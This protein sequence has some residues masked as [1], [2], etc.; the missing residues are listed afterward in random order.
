MSKYLIS[1]GSRCCRPVVV[2]T[3]D[4]STCEAEALDLCEIEAILAY[5]VSSRKTRAMQ[6]SLS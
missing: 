1:K 5:R 6:N 2:R 3:F 4:L